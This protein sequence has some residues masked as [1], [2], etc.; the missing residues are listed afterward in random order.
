MDIEGSKG[1]KQK[2]RSRRGILIISIPT[3]DYEEITALCPNLHYKY[4]TKYK[5]IFVNYL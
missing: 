4:N 3:E 2:G 1:I 5:I